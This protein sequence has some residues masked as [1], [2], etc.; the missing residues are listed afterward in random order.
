MNPM[1][2][3]KSIFL[4]FRILLVLLMIAPSWGPYRT[5]NAGSMIPRRVNIPY[6]GPTYP[7]PVY[8][9]GVFW[10]G[11]V[12]A[13]DNY[14]DVRIV[15]YGN[16]IR[17][18]VHIIDRTIWYDTNPSKNDLTNWDSVTIL[19]NKSGTT[20]TQP[21]SS[22]YRFDGQIT[23]WEARA[24]YQAAYQGNGTSWSPV[25]IPF[26][27]PASWRG[28][29]VPDDTQD[30]KGWEI[31]FDIP[32]TSLGLTSAPA[33]GTIWGLGV[34]LHDRDDAAGTSIRHTT[35]PETLQQ[36][37]PSTYGVMNFGIPTYQSQVADPIDPITIRQGKNGVTVTDGEVGGHT[38]CGAAFEPNFWSGWGDANYKGYSQVNIQNQWDIADWPCFSKYYVT[39]PLTTLP[40]GYK[41]ISATLTMYLFGG[42]GGTPPDTYIQ[43]F[44]VGEDWDPNT[45]SWNNAPYVSEN[46]SG[47]WV[48]PYPKTTPDWPGL[49]YQWDVS[50]ALAQAYAAGTPLR[51]AMYEGDGG[52]HTGKY[53]SSS[54]VGDW[55][56]VGRPT[57]TVRLG[58]PTCGTSSTSPCH[59]V[60]LPQIIN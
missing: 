18:N 2:A 39:F 22:T 20:G 15:Y 48:Q 26:T 35:W 31:T 42:S 24:N 7:A 1:Q 27:T 11:K 10:F 23:W 57:L 21:S 55:N 36:D 50:R 38:T 16:T 46:V 29:G 44:T 40:A 25:D 60:F 14:A 28:D 58:K 47:T 17:I 5:V 9:P 53:F 13:S 59:A 41:V 3:K 56:A 45:L 19:L 6:G 54:A 49:P 12:N 30:K 37:Q 51:L 52:Y 8:T 33:Q 4:V 34:I 43:T 32:F